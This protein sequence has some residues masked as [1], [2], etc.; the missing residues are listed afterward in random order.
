M[1]HKKHSVH[2]QAESAA[3][4]SAQGHVNTPP[5]K[6]CYP[7]AAILMADGLVSRESTPVPLAPSDQTPGAAEWGCSARNFWP[8]MMPFGAGLSGL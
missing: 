7:E 1:K 4:R 6:H 3:G 2:E 5:L 8:Q